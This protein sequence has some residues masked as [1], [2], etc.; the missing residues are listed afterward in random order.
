MVIVEDE[1]EGIKPRQRDSRSS[2]ESPSKVD[3]S[4]DVR[5][6]EDSRVPPDVPFGG[7][8]NMPSPASIPLP[9]S[10]PPSGAVVGADDEDDEN[11]RSDVS[12]P[13]IQDSR[14]NGHKSHGRAVEEYDPSQPLTSSDEE[15]HS[16]KLTQRSS[17]RRTPEK[18]PQKQPP[19][20]PGRVSS[21]KEAREKLEDT[22]SALDLS[23]IPLPS[24]DHGK[25]HDD[26]R[27][28]PTIQFSIPTRHKLLSISSLMKRQK[29]VAKKESKNALSFS[30]EISKAF[31]EDKQD[32]SD[33][34]NEKSD[35][36]KVSLVAEIFGSDDEEEKINNAD[37]DSSSS[38]AG[39]LVA[40]KPVEPALLPGKIPLLPPAPNPVPAVLPDLVEQ[41]QPAPV[42]PPVVSAA[43]KSSMWRQIV[44][45]DTS[46][47]AESQPDTP[48]LEDAP[49]AQPPLV[50][51]EDSNDSIA[52]L[53]TVQKSN[54]TT[55]DDDIQVVGFTPAKEKRAKELPKK[56]PST[57]K[58]KGS[59]LES[60]SEGDSEFERQSRRGD[61][62]A[63][64][65]KRKSRRDRVKE[66]P[67][68]NKE[69]K[70][71]RRR[72]SQSSVSNREEG[73]IVDSPEKRRKKRKDKKKAKKRKRSKNG[74]TAIDFSEKK[75]T[76]V[77]TSLRHSSE[78]ENMG[79][80]VVAW[81]K[82]S[83]SAKERNYRYVSSNEIESFS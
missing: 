45:E 59:Q 74:K 52:V 82:P 73:E 11:A 77:S 44:T 47:V 8:P 23:S 24:D 34:E 46:T 48:P 62:S 79:D 39:G 75:I 78:E 20:R 12:S 27:V 72:R 26:N 6:T 4:D 53:E 14:R 67:K 25:S 56:Q 17:S 51:D 61:G 49:I 54:K 64:E 31:G 43:E 80:S 16:I 66:K 40:D 33:E 58:E 28:R 15:E 63:A 19:M 81:R 57:E 70:T 71:S 65:S 13:D 18:S 30:S 7:F 2:A 22:P 1:V 38:A 69:R 36:P 83:N 32:E 55:E 5:S 41:V 68:D 37:N 76:D 50:E 10:P 21:N 9:D 29:G 60:I 3:V 42:L 35:E